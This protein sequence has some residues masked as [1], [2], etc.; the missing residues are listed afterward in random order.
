MH[1]NGAAFPGVAIGVWSDTWV[2]NVA[3][4]EASGKYEVSLTGLPDG[5]YKVAVVTWETCTEQEGRRTAHKC[6]LQSEIV[7]IVNNQ[8]C[9]A[10]DASQ[11][12]VIDFIG[13]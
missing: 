8:D 7:T 12:T 13:P 1:A 3:Q 11:V 2:G 10:A 9:N 5:T 4:S 6:Q